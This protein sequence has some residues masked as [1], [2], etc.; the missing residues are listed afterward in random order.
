MYLLVV[1][2]DETVARWASQTSDLGGGNS[3][4]PLVLGPGAVPE[5][6]DAHRARADPE[7][8]VLSAMAHGKDPDIDMAARIA[9]VAVEASLDLD[10]DR[11][12][13]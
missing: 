5:V 11:S 12:R 6:T 10:G 1:T 7:L 13:L 4:R 3:F 8:A 9:S 2:I